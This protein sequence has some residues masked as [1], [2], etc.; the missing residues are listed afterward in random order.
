MNTTGDLIARA[1]EALSNADALIV[2]AGAGMGVDSGLPDFRGTE[3]FWRA[4]PA[5][6]HANFSFQDIASPQ[7]F[8]EMPALAWGFYGHRLKLYRSTTPH[9]GYAI[10]LR[11][12]RLM[13]NGAFVFTSNVDGHFQKSG[14]PESRIVECH[15]SI[16][17]LQCLLN[18]SDR[19]W[20][21]AH[22]RP[23]VDPETCKLLVPFPRCPDCGGLAR[24]NVLMFNDYS[25]VSHWYDRR[26]EALDAW[27]RDAGKVVVV[28]LGAGKAIPTVR[29]FGARVGNPLIRINTEG[30]PHA[31]GKIIHL[32]GSALEVLRR[33]D[34][35][36]SPD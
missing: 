28:E 25:W 13:R 32:Q 11:W 7:A 33:I 9:E 20:G 12:T 31:G 1:A 8:H 4:Y 21:S 17:V 24:P 29:Q 22:F 23:Q 16:H 14:F 26:R 2:T 6:K 27:H 30:V 34:G 5:L 36:L 3:G 18:C 19:T 35:A 10:L 15:G